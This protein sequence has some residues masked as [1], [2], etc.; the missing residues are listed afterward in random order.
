MD[1]GELLQLLLPGGGR[2]LT[3]DLK[4]FHPVPKEAYTADTIDYMKAIVDGGI[5]PDPLAW[6]A[7]DNAAAFQQQKMGMTFMANGLC[8]LEDPSKS[9]VAGKVGYRAPSSTSRRGPSAT[10]FG[11]T[12]NLAIDKNSKNQEAAWEFVKL[13]VSD[14]EAAKDMA[15]NGKNTTTILS[16]LDTR[17]C[18]RRS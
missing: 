1:P 12:W 16:L 18:S 11:N 17:R 14:M 6:T 13:C 15:V 7:D 4:G 10:T 8:P 5:T 3:D 9:Q 2:F